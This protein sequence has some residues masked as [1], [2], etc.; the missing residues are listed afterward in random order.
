MPSNPNFNYL[1]RDFDSLKNDL[2]NY[3]K[4]Y[5]PDRYTDFSES[6][7]GMMLLELNAYVGDILSYHVDKN[8]NELWMDTAQ[9]RDSVLRIA[10]NLGY[11]PGGKKPA[12]TLLDVTINVPPDG[13]SF[14]TD[15]LI[16]IQGFRASSP[17]GAYFEVSDSIDFSSH[18]AVTGTVNRFVEPVYNSSN[19]IVSYNITKRVAAV[20][21]ETKYGVLEITDTNS[22][23]YLKWNIDNTD[24]NITEV[25]SVI[26]K[27][28]R[29][30]PTTLADWTD[31]GQYTAWYK[32]DSLPQ[33]RVF[34]DTSTGTTGSEGYWKYIEKRYT[35][36]Y[37]DN[38]HVYLTFGA[39]L[40][41]YNSYNDFISGGVNTLTSETLL[42]N[43]SLGEIPSPGTYLHVQYRTGG[44]STTNSAANT[45]TN[46]VAKTVSNVPG[47]AGLP[48]GVLNGVINSMVVTNPIPAIGGRDFPTVDEIK[49]YAEGHYAAQDRCVTVDDYISRISLMPSDYGNVFRSYAQADPDSMNTR[50]YILTKDETG[51]LK[52]SGNDQIKSNIAAYLANYKV[53][54]DFVVLDDGRII[55][56]G[57]N[58]TVQ[59]DKA[60]NKRDVITNCINRLIDYF[61]IDR[62][63]MSDTI[64][65]SQ[66]SEMLR[67]QPGVVN[68]VSIQF[69][70]KV[71]GD[72]S[73]DILASNYNLTQVVKL[74]QDGEVDIVPDSNKIKAPLTG[75]FEIKYPN[76]DIKGAAI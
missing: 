28:N 45:V 25:I 37:D 66:V 2:M 54:N 12:V 50:I 19:E 16:T 40:Q 67:D 46:V 69:K 74:A 47:G 11:K 26:G 10:K 33:E 70:N 62:W 73:S 20:A 43:D 1:N 63:Q 9:N 48:T 31:S 51:R 35:M 7:V 30:T 53:L 21:G 65:I 14:D 60:Y 15:Y 22:V 32:V 3:V 52:N 49:T 71:G 24:P 72:Y 75:M 68:V 13:D 59:I 38:G 64:Y 44:G 4:V 41:D 17:S 61:K 34:V 58:F 39:G 8:F 27:D 57:I 36:D 42:N 5:Y 6:S 56:I 55:N 29:Y 76:V 18:S 23:P